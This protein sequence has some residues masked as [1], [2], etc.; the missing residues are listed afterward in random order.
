M[1]E[2]V[3]IPLLPVQ[4][5]STTLVHFESLIRQTIARL[6]ILLLEYRTCLVADVVTGKLDVRE[7]AANLP[8][9]PEEPVAP[10]LAEMLEAEEV[11]GEALEAVE[12][13]VGA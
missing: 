13:E 4:K 2:K 10:E 11:D 12:A 8:D 9:E 3:P 7:A 1:K 5:Q 6:V